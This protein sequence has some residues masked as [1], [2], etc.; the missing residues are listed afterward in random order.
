MD[1]SRCGFEIRKRK[2]EPIPGPASLLE[3]EDTAPHNI[4]RVRT[5]D[6]YCIP[7][8]CCTCSVTWKMY[9]LSNK[10]KWWLVLWHLPPAGAGISVS[11]IM[12]FVPLGFTLGGCGLLCRWPNQPVSQMC[13]LYEGKVKKNLSGHE[14]MPLYTCAKCLEKVWWIDMTNSMDQSPSWESD[15]FSAGQYITWFYGT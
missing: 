10:N 9:G 8:Q 1:V 15:N 12:T 14:A 3:T 13:D 7:K 11:S 4:H 6:N 5:R 2:L